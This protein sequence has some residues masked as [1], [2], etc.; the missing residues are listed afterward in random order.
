MVI[1]SRA[2]LSLSIY[3]GQ[4]SEV[5]GPVSSFDTIALIIDDLHLNRVSSCYSLTVIISVVRTGASGGLLL[6]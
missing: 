5:D 3:S 6:A 2:L 4:F 1:L